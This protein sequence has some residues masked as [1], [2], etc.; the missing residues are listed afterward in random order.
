MTSRQAPPARRLGV[1]R[2]VFVLVV[3]LVGVVL[4]VHLS[5]GWYLAD[6][7]AED[8]LLPHP[9]TDDDVEL[10][11]VDGEIGA[12]LADP[13]HDGRIARGDVM[14]FETDAG[15]LRLGPVVARE[16]SVVERPL[17]LV[18]GEMP[19][20]PIRGF[21][22]PYAYPLDPEGIRLDVEPVEYETPLGPMDAWYA[23]GTGSVWVIH[24]HGGGT[25]LQEPLRLMH[26]LARGG[27]HQLAITYRND[28][29]Q[30]PDPSG[31]YRYGRTEWADLEG[32]VEFARERGARR[33][34]LTGFSNGASIVLAYLYRSPVG[35]A[36]AILDS[37]IIDLE[38]MLIENSETRELAFGSAVPPSLLRA[39]LFFT[40][41]RF[42]VNWDAIDYIA[43]SNRLAVPVLVFHGTADTTVSVR[44][45]R[46]FAESAPSL[47]TLVEVDGAGHR[48]SW[49]ADPDTYAFR[50][51]EFVADVLR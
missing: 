8:A 32:A 33:I 27:Y 28:I 11:A 10:V 49:N 24:V 36:G 25:T 4:V 30:P 17:E 35:I 22:E 16:G 46:R 43:R 37:P 18:V 14:G 6:R 40:A 20:P 3:A 44:S 50:A 38:Q 34:V 13:E 47:V 31:L 41:L 42:D 48:E 1:R 5:G 9:W 19:V 15:Y 51:A 7:I 29:G 12:F 45:S 2:L 23:E 39:G 21:V 26:V